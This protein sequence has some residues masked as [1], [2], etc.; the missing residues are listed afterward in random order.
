[1]TAV[2]ARSARQFVRGAVHRLAG[3]VVCE[4]HA[5]EFL[6]EAMRLASEGLRHQRA[7]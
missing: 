6:K 3:D 5:C 1:M 4:E 2:L 7:A